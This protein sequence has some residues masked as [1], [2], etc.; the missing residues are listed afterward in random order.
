MYKTYILFD[1][2]LS[3]M[4]VVSAVRVVAVGDRELCRLRVLL[5]HD[6]KSQIR[7]TRSLLLLSLL[8][9]RYGT[10]VECLA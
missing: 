8:V 2:H 7:R 5:L 6:P 1:V 4:G 9:P 10:L 3:E